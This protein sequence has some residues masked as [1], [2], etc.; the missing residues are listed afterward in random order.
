MIKAKND[1]VGRQVR[2]RGMEL[3]EITPVIFGGDP[4]DPKNKIWLTRGEH[5]EAVRYWNRVIRELRG[6]H[7]SLKS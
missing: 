4:I 1:D 6:A 2:P 7:D 5:F 3:F